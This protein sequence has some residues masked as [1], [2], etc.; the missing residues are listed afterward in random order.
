MRGRRTTHHS[1]L[2]TGLLLSTLA[3]APLAPLAAQEASAPTDPAPPE[4]V[5]QEEPKGWL[6]SWTSGWEGSV[7]LGL[8]GASGNAENFNARGGVDGTRETDAH[9]SRFDI[10]YTFGQN[11]GETS[12]N[13]FSAGARNDW[14][15]EGS[16]WR[17]FALT[18]LESDQFQDWRWRSSTFGGVGY[19][20]VDEEDLK[21]IG[22]LGA[23]VRYDFTG[24][25]QGFTPEGI[26]GADYEQ[27]L[28]ERQKVRATIDFF[29]SFD[30]ITDYRFEAMAEWVL[31]VDPESN[32]SLI[33]GIIDRYDATPGD[34][35]NRNDINYYALLN[36]AY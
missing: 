3:L 1:P 26:I 15:L 20:F 5:A 31:L 32:L 35:F 22:R 28:T 16:K 25:S 12:N 9:A 14:K 10:S 27:T 19:A 33:V 29:P 7:S 18:H 8:N 23:G 11:E 21:F 4:A 24:D 34:G 36:W 2:H 6:G 17:P 30:T 13:Y